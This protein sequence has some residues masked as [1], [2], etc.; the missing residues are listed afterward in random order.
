MALAELLQLIRTQVRAELEA[1]QARVAS[2]MPVSQES[3]AKTAAT[4]HQQGMRFP[5]SRAAQ[6]SHLIQGMQLITV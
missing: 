6:L 3:H 1:Q 5:S 2:D 4:M